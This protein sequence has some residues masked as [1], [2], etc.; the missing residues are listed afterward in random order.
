M[1]SGQ[2]LVELALLDTE[3]ERTEARGRIGLYKGFQMITCTK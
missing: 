3:L 2:R 1:I